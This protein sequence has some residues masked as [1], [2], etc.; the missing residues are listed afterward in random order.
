MKALSCVVSLKEFKEKA[1]AGEVEGLSIRRQFVLDEVKEVEGQ[2]RVLQ[3]TIS[4]ATVDR[5]GDTIAASGW[6]LDNFMRN[7]VVQFAHEYNQPPVA[8][9][10]A[11]WVENGRLRSRAEF[12]LPDLYAFSA[13]KDSIPATPLS[14][15]LRHC[16][17]RRPS[18]R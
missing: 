4:S 14:L 15:S 5:D 1:L 9:A 13:L 17:C 6:R 8:R 12:T 11:T 2:D 18:D 16:L 7:P 3:F 10:L